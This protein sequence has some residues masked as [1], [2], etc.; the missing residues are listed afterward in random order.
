MPMR[1]ATLLL[2]LALAGSQGPV[3]VPSVLDTAV[4][5]QMD[6][7]GKHAYEQ[8][9]LLG[10]L[11]R[12]FAIAPSGEYGGAWGL[13]S[14]EAARAAALKTCADKGTGRCELYAE[15][16]DVVW[17]GR[18]PP[19]HPD[20][21]AQLIGDGRYAFAP[22]PRFLWHGPEAASGVLVWAHGYGGP[23]ADHRGLQP[24]PFTRAFNNAGFDIVRFERDPAW[25]ARRE[26][27]A[28]QLRAGLIELRRRG[29]RLIVAGG[30]S[31][32][33]FNALQMLSTP[34]VVDAVIALSPGGGQGTDP[35]A[36]A[37]FKP[38]EN[39]QLVQSVRAPDARV[40]FAQFNDDPYAPDEDG[41]AR[42]L[43]ED[44]APRV[45]RLLLIDRPPGLR[46]HGGGEGAGFAER[47]GACLLR[48][49][50]AA[51]P[52]SSC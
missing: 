7:T 1:R 35:E 36:I 47:Y 34:G 18:V 13:R 37:A 40:V 44:L 32:G 41:R 2:L 31:R 22:D 9:F 39:R 38:A 4:L 46:G 17:N 12:A 45:A 24:P 28:G 5:P 8:H 10:N 42:L 27:V 3:S 19:P 51:R 21:P 23:A 26:E 43:R 14:A 15:D 48:F 6:A 52:P 16:L 49:V 29:W 50:T 33:G 25:D 20:L 30:Q 11:P